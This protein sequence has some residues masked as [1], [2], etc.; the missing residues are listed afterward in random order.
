MDVIAKCAFG[1][2]I[3]NLD[4]DNDEFMKNTPTSF[5]S[6][7]SKSPM[8]LFACEQRPTS[9]PAHIPV[10]FCEPTSD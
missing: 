7:V 9:I 3:D 6:A 4:D 5:F 8:V 10:H 1:M 2:T